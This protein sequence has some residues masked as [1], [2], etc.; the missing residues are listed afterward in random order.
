MIKWLFEYF[1]AIDE[2]ADLWHI[3]PEACRYL[4]NEMGWSNLKIVVVSFIIAITL[5]VVPGII[6]KSIWNKFKN[7]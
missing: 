7:L 4:E 5:I 3:W 6:I 2:F 1:T